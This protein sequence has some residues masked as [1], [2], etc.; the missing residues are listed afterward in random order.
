MTEAGWSRQ[1]EVLNARL[2]AGWLTPDRWR[3]LLD[4]E[5]EAAAP[6]LRYLSHL[7]GDDRRARPSSTRSVPSSSPPAR[8]A[9]TRYTSTHLTDDADQPALRAVDALGALWAADRAQGGRRTVA[10]DTAAL[11]GDLFAER[12]CS[13]SA[14]TTAPSP[15]PSLSA[16]APHCGVV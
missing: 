8:T 9:S 12:A 15:R 5:K 2:V 6:V 13:P 7:A 10:W 4:G 16:G 1:F 3:E 11:G 14:R